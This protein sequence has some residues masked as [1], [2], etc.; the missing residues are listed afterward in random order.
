MSRE[1]CNACP[2]WIS[3]MRLGAIIR[4]INNEEL[5]QP[6]HAD[7]LMGHPINSVIKNI[8]GV[9]VMGEGVVQSPM[10]RH[11][12]EKSALSMVSTKWRNYL[13]TPT[14]SRVCLKCY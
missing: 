13:R 3:G 2:D 10:F 7:G 1:D 12:W 11:L 14:F 9:I 5:G 4:K 8:V 6:L